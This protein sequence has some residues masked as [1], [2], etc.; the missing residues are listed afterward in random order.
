MN[1][2]F[3]KGKNIDFDNYEYKFI[4]FYDGSKNNLIIFN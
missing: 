2:L 3:N 4:N 1:M